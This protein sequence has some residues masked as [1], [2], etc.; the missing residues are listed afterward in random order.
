MNSPSDG[1][2]V[3]HPYE[4]GYWSRYLGHRRSR[5]RSRAWRNGWSDCDRELREEARDGEA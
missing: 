4:R 2:V 3:R 5:G 1:R